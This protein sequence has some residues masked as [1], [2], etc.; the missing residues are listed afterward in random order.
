MLEEVL[1]DGE[2]EEMASVKPGSME[3]PSM[4]EKAEQ[5]LTQFNTTV[6]AVLSPLI[7]IFTIIIVVIKATLSECRL[8]TRLCAKCFRD[9]SL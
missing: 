1:G 9:T 5:R 4:S 3:V 7:P 8:H 6:V 2:G